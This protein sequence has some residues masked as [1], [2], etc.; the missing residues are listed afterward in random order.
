M[1]EP[2][3]P[4]KPRVSSEEAKRIL[5][6]S[7][8]ELFQTI[9]SNEITTRRISEHTGFDTKTIFRNFETLEGL[10]V[11]ALRILE[12]PLIREEPITEY[13]PVASTQLYF[14]FYTWLQHLGISTQRLA[15]DTAFSE[16]LR[17]H[18]YQR[19]RLSEDLSDRAK[20]AFLNL[21]VSFLHSQVDFLPGQ[22]N[23]FPPDSVDD[24]AAL[25]DAILRHMPVF[26]KELNWEDGDDLE[27]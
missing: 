23:M 13:T 21:G 1:T 10:Y 7:V 2:T 6:D 8:I 15:A 4:K 17:S 9:P 18:S 19:L 24:T 5:I 22:P 26:A 11:A 14:E 25:L 12:P 16:K 20:Q 3:Q 27:P